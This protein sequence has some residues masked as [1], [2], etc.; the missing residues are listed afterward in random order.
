MSVCVET[1]SFSQT[2]TQVLLATSKHFPFAVGDG[3]HRDAS[4]RFHI[5]RWLQPLCVEPPSRNIPAAGTVDGGSKQGAHAGCIQL[6]ILGAADSFRLPKDAAAGRRFAAV[7]CG[8]GDDRFSS[9][10]RQLKP[11]SGIQGPLY[12]SSESLLVHCSSLANEVR[13]RYA[14]V[15]RSSMGK[16]LLARI[17]IPNRFCGMNAT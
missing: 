15:T 3:H 1:M 13:I 11:L 4:K 12:F 17:T 5:R 10:R 6:D 14:T 8:A 7:E 2:T 16:F 9:I